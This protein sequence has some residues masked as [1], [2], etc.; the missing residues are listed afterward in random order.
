M[1][2]AIPERLLIYHAGTSKIVFLGILKVT[3]IFIFAGTLMVAAPAINSDDPQQAWVLPA[4]NL[5]I[6]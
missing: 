1:I 6:M 4:G 2:L 5:I 3:T